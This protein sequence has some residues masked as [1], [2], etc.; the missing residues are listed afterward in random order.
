MTSINKLDQNN[1]IFGLEKPL[2]RFLFLL[3]S[4]LFASFVSL[5]LSILLRFGFIFPAE[6]KPKFIGWWLGLF[7]FQMLILLFF[8][9][10][11]ITLRFVGITE[12]F[13]LINGFLVSTGITLFVLFFT[14]TFLHLPKNFSLGVLLI[15]NLLSFACYGIIRV[16]RRLHEE[17]KYSHHRTGKHTLIIGANIKSERLIKEM[18]LSRSNLEPIA[19]A[20]VESKHLGQEIYK[21]PVYDYHTDIS[22]IIR[23]HA[24]ETALINL[25]NSSHHL[26]KSVFEKIRLH[27][28]KDIRIVPGMDDW[29]SEINSIRKIDIE[30][31]LARDPVRIE[32]QSIEMELAGKKIMVTGAAGSIGSEIVRKLLRLGAEQVM[33]I[34]MDETGIF[35]LQQ[36]LKPILKSA[37]FNFIVGSIADE[38]KMRRVFR[39]YGPN[40]LFHAAAYKHVPLMEDYPEEALQT[41]VLGTFTLAQLAIEFKIEKFINIS[42]DKAVKPTSVMGASK[43]LAEMIC[44]ALNGN[45]TRF[46]SV[47]FGNVLGSRGSVVP[48]FQEQIRHGGPITITHREMRRYFMSIP[49]A[50]LLVLQASHQ[51]KGGEVFV[52]DM[53]EPVRI[54]DLAESLIRLNGLEPGREIDIVFSG[55]RPGEKLFEELLTAEEGVDATN[56]K[57]IFIAR[58]SSSVPDDFL[59]RLLADCHQAIENPESIRPFFSQYIPM[60]KE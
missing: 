34:D 7:L 51:G 28:V 1:R 4:D 40:I 52:L 29:K 53:G 54:V 42:T 36:E 60:Y 12:F 39:Q 27:G 11:R 2:A 57:K 56:H 46:L 26:I 45:G 59:P 24:I 49:E 25:P 22:R 16:A 17:I 37:K 14:R 31:L 5:Y 18:R 50:V 21:L 58:F 48:L 10:Y 41:N 47:R 43:R 20:D 19:I 23:G 13:R 33:A 15:Y 55:I 8:N 9:L 32:S 38:N 35:Q 44:Q 30:D 3:V 6:Y